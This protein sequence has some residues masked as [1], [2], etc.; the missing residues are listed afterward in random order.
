[1]VPQGVQPQL[2]GG[3][4]DQ[5][6]CLSHLQDVGASWWEVVSVTHQGPSDA[7]ELYHSTQDSS[8]LWT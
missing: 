1:M 6:A 5:S 2:F 7:L 8:L 3:R 4:F